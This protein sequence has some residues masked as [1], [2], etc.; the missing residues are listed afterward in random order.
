MLTVEPRMIFDHVIRTDPQLEAMVSGDEIVDFERL[1]ECVDWLCGDLSACGVRAGQRVGLCIREGWHFVLALHALVRLDTVV[2]PL[3]SLD[4]EAL[5]GARDLDLHFVV[6]HSVENDLVEDVAAQIGKADFSP[7]FSVADE[8]TL[9][10][11]GDG[12]VGD[13]GGLMLGDADGQ[14]WEWPRCADAVTAV[15]DGLDLH[16]QGRVMVCGSCESTETVLLVLACATAGSC[17]HIGP[18]PADSSVWSDPDHEEISVLCAPES[19]AFA[20][21]EQAPQRIRRQL[22]LT[23][24][25]RDVLPEVIMRRYGLVRDT[26]ANCAVYRFANHPTRQSGKGRRGRSIGLRSVS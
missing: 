19:W 25:S 5:A 8:F 26:V 9:I 23:L 7:M 6:S 3:S 17:V 4:D 18:A 15:R 10:A 13:G 12:P 2:V 24:A 20:L 11:V 14:V 1:D 21:I 22:A 16:S